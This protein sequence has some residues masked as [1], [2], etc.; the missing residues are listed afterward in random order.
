MGESSEREKIERHLENGETAEAQEI[1]S[2]P[3]TS[4]VLVDVYTELLKVPLDETGLLKAMQKHSTS[5]IPHLSY[6]DF[7]VRKERLREGISQYKTAAKV[8]KIPEDLPQ[9]LKTIAF[10]HL[11]LREVTEAFHTGWTLIQIS[12]TTYN[13]RLLRNICEIARKANPPLSIRREA[14]KTEE[15]IGKTLTRRSPVERESVKMG[16]LEVIGCRGVGEFLKSNGIE[17]SG[18]FEVGHSSGDLPVLVLLEKHRFDE[19]MRSLQEFFVSPEERTGEPSCD[20]IKHL[21]KAEDIHL[22]LRIGEYMYRNSHYVSAAAVFGVCIDLF[23]RIDALRTKFMQLAVTL[24]YPFFQDVY[25]ASPGIYS[26]YSEAVK[27]H[28]ISVHIVKRGQV[29]EHPLDKILA[30]NFP[31]KISTEARTPLG[32]PA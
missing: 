6:G 25:E 23:S 14:E 5:H 31:E 10:L 11:Q 12:P 3:G 1:L 30:E 27:K 13:M 9:I 32:K 20:V 22:L 28:N 15:V 7:L 21:M 18:P 26:E 24:D 29:K 4:E 16:D 17:A 19:F 2:T 8:C